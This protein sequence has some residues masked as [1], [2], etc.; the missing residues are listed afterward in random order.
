[1]NFELS[2]DTNHS[3][4]MVPRTIAESKSFMFSLL[5]L[6]NLSFAS[7]QKIS[8]SGIGTQRK[9]QV[10]EP[11]AAPS[12]GCGSGLWSNPVCKC[13]CVTNYCRDTATGACTAVRRLV[14]LSSSVQH[15]MISLFM[16]FPF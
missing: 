10:L 14:F 3:T 2:A 7:S 13:L 5:I 12:E 15:L 16:F 8:D 6:V 4:W 9:E 1:M 11:C